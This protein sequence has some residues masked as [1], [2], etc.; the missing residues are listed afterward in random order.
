MLVSFC[1]LLDF[2][3]GCLERVYPVPLQ[4]RWLWEPRTVLC[5]VLTMHLLQVTEG[6][7]APCWVGCL[8]LFFLLSF[9]SLE[10]KHCKYLTNLFQRERN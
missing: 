3:K 7:A 1:M 10:Q 8:L 4:T 5:A 9:V 2:E 6:A